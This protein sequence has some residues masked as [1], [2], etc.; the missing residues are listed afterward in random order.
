MG[1][2]VNLYPNA[3]LCPPPLVASLVAY[4][5]D[6]R[7]ETGGFLRAVLEN[8]LIG[9]INKAD[10]INLIYLPHIAAYIYNRLPSGSWGSPEK[11]A[12]WLARDPSTLYHT[13]TL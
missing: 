13:V 10:H 7:Q 3:N 9:A 2:P 5:S 4:A 6:R 1:D 8:D 11:V 12:K